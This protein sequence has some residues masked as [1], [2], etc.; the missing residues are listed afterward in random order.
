LKNHSGFKASSG[1]PALPADIATILDITNDLFS[2][3]EEAVPLNQEKWFHFAHPGLEEYCLDML[4]FFS[5]A[6]LKEHLLHSNKPAPTAL[7]AVAAGYVSAELFL[8]LHIPYLPSNSL[9]TLFCSWL[10]MIWM[11]SVP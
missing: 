1:F 10:C 11:P 2:I 4:S 7:L 5:P 3:E 6:H 8:V 9:N